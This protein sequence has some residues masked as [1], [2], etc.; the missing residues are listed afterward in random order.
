MARG[1]CPLWRWGRAAFYGTRFIATRESLAPEMYK[2]ALLERLVN[3]MIRTDA[4]SGRAAQALSNAISG[5]YAQAGAAVLT[6]SWQLPAAS[7]I[8]QAA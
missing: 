5:E 7:E 3:A 1:P 6:S 2:K 8:Y 4:F